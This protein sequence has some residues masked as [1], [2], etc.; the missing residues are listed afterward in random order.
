[1]HDDDEAPGKERRFGLT[2][3]FDC[4]YIAINRELRPN[5]GA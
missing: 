5:T 4:Q 1:M 3:H 2:P